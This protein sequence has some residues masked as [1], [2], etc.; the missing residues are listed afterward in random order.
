MGSP[1]GSDFCVTTIGKKS[2]NSDSGSVTDD[3]YLDLRFTGWTIAGGGGFSYDRAVA[4]AAPPPTGD[5]NHNDVIDAADY[6]VWRHTFGQTGVTQGTGADGNSNGMIDDGDYGY[7]RARFGN[8]VAPSG[9]GTVANVPEPNTAL[10]TLV[11][12]GLLRVMGF[13]A[14]QRQRVHASLQSEPCARKFA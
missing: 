6:V 8:N 12:L 11:G 9:F 10:G 4:P 3:V 14:R 7:W 13:S 5:Y 2:L 1:N